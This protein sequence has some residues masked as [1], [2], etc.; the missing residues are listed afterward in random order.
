MAVSNRDRVGDGLHLLGIEL[1]LFIDQR[2]TS[3]SP[4]GSHWKAAYPN[5]NLDS[6]VSA[7]TGVV[8]D[9]WDGVFRDILHNMGR[10]LVHEV[11]E[12]RNRW[13]HSES[14]SHDDVDWALD[15]MQRLLRLIGVHNVLA[16][17]TTPIATSPPDVSNRDESVVAKANSSPH[18]VHFMDDE[19]GYSAW[20]T[21]HSNGY[22]LNCA[23][24]PRAAYLKLHKA[25]CR[26][27]SGKP[28]RGD[29]WT[30]AYAKVCAGTVS[31]LDAW[32]EQRTGAIPARCGTCRP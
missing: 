19:A 10:T 30:T 20:L 12:W 25:A 9:H 28:P 17:R 18:A 6:D 31:E 13:A 24:Q 22:V 8:L 3:S 5:A 7:Q 27:I 2:M 14:F 1:G 23:R 26:W 4:L 21:A 16:V 32:A 29:T 15:T 11:R